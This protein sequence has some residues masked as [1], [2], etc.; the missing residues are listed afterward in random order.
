MS[1]GY[2]QWTKIGCFRW[3]RSGCFRRTLTFSLFI[4]SFKWP[5]IFV[6]ILLVVDYI[7]RSAADADAFQGECSEMPIIVS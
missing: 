4:Q 6:N 7:L 1:I 2:F 3:T 5:L